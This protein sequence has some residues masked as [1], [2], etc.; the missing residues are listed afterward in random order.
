MAKEIKEGWAKGK[1]FRCHGFEGTCARLDI[2]H[3]LTKPNHPWTN[4]QVERMNRTLKEA[5]LRRYYY[6]SHDQLREHLDAFVNA[7]NYAKRLK[8]LKGRTPHEFI[9]K[10][11]TEEPKRFRVNPN[12]LSTGLY[13]WTLGA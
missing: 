6:S 2:D 3:R 1:R 8:T 12:H 5:T 10:C 13:S 7:Y 9:T 4:G 11:W